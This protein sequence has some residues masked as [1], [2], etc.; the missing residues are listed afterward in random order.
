[1]PTDAIA[2]VRVSTAGQATEDRAGLD[3]QRATIARIAREHDL[4]ILREVEL[5]ISGTRVL[6]DPRFLGVLTAIEAP[7]IRGV[8]VSEL[9]RLMRPEDPAYYAIFGRFR[10][11]GTIL[12]TAEGAQ[13]FRRDR[14]LMMMRSEIAAW[15]RE[16]FRERTM[17]GKEVLRRRGV[18]VAGP[19][20]LPYGVAWSREEGWSYRWP[21][22]GIARQVYERVLA[23]EGN[24]SRLARELE[25]SRTLV[26]RILANPIYAGVRRI[27]HR[28]PRGRAM[29]R[30][31]EDVIE[32]VVLD[33]P[34]VPMAWWEA[35]QP[36]LADRRPQVRGE[37]PC[38]YRGI[39]WCAAC[40]VPLHAHRDAHGSAGRWGYRCRTAAR[41]PS[42]AVGWIQREA[43]EAAADRAI[44]AH[45]AR[46]EVL[47]VALRAARD[48]EVTAGLSREEAERRVAGLGRERE[49]VIAGYERGLR[50]LPEAEAR[51]R[52]IDAEIRA[53]RRS[54]AP[55]LRESEEAL[56]ARIA[57]PFASWDLLTG[58]QRRRLAAAAIRRLEVEREGRAMAR[59]AAVVLR[60]APDPTLPPDP[61]RV[62]EY[63][64]PEGVVV[65]CW[66]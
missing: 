60:I 51:L 11:T 40:G 47:A 42:C 5:T 30:A 48:R 55:P 19:E 2:I 46:P 44:V 9:D 17:R 66:Q 8:V 35:V 49:R 36:A 12:Y 65:A 7:E 57:R 18:H 22:A 29:P 34:L 52:A 10:E 38:L 61:A 14:L 32:Q 39:A 53:L 50:T 28:W 15:E 56:A 4:R 20:G 31:T 16:R 23:G 13:D 63:G 27:A 24:F 45:V 41:G 64:A 6:D 59:V 33:P 26:R 54:A 37:S 1:M 21:E 3:G 58:D 25:I 43:V 62:Q